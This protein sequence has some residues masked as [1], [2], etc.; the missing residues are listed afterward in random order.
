MNTHN[1]GLGKPFCAILKSFFHIFSINSVF[2]LVT[3]NDRYKN[4][5]EEA[6]N[7]FLGPPPLGAL[8]Q[9]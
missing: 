3:A 5:P 7:F 9:I 6:F 2:N 8:G 4:S 1:T